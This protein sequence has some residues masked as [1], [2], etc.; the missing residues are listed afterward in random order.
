[1]IQRILLGVDGSEGSEGAVRHALALADATDATLHVLAVVETLDRAG[2][3][4]SGDPDTPEQDAPDPDWPEKT[5]ADVTARAADRGVPVETTVERGVPYRRIVDHARTADLVV[6]GRH[7]TGGLR[8]FLLGSTAERVVRRSP[9]PVLTPETDTLARPRYDTLLLCLDGS[10]GARAAIPPVTDLAQACDA[11][12]HVLSVVDTT[13]FDP[14]VVVDLLGGFE[15]LAEGVVERVADDL[16]SAGVETVTAV[17]RGVAS[18]TIRTYAS[19][20]GADLVAMGV[21]GATG[22]EA[23][24][25]GSTTAK[26]LRAGE[27][28]M[29]TAPR[30]SDSPAPSV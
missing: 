16:A 30:P 8:E 26:V 12:V 3:A 15:T 23:S 2:E 18:A 22:L 7:G 29:L 4:V 19:R 20:V 10:D 21:T 25:L 28:P 17:E 14:D 24:L 11:T 5:L 1:M 6:V 13:P 9:V 27:R